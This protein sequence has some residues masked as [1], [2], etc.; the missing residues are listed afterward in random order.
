[1]RQILEVVVRNWLE[2]WQMSWTR[3]CRWVGHW[4][5]LPACGRP[6]TP[7]RNRALSPTAGEGR[8]RSGTVCAVHSLLSPVYCKNSKT[9]SKKETGKGKAFEQPIKWW[10]EGKEAAFGRPIKYWRE[11]GSLRMRLHYWHSLVMSVF[12]PHFQNSLPVTQNPYSLG[13]QHAIKARYTSGA[14]ER[15]L[16]QAWRGNSQIFGGFL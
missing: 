14:S 1:M 6:L 2:Q 8:D 7:H 13:T 15:Y 3:H 11:E 10:R 4:G 16:G 5:R 12:I 9:G